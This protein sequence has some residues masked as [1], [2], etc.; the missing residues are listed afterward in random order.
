MSFETLTGTTSNNFFIGNQPEAQTDTFIY[1]NNRMAH[2]P[3]LKYNHSIFAWEFSNDG[4][5]SL[6]FGSSTGTSS[7]KYLSDI[8]GGSWA[9]GYYHLT[10]TQHTWLTSGTTDGYWKSNKGGTGFTTYATGDILY[11]SATNVLSK[12]PIGTSGQVLTVSGSNVPTWT[13]ISTSTTHNTLSELQGG[14]TNEYYHLTSAQHVWLTGG[15]AAGYW[16]AVKGGTGQI[17]YTVGDILY[18]NST[19]TLKTLKIGTL[20]Q[21]LT[22]SDSNEP[23]WATLEPII[24]HNNLIEMQGGTDNEYYHLTSAQHTWLT[25]GVTAGYWSAAKGGTGQT[26]Y[27]VGDI[28][29]AN[30]T[31]TLKTLTVGTIGQVLTVSESNVPSWT[32]I[33][34]ISTHNGLSS[35]QGGTTNEYYHLTSAQHTWLTAGVADGYWGATKGGTGF[36]SY[37]VG[38]ILYASSTS[39][40]KKLTIGNNGQILT[41]AAGVPT[42]AA[43]LTG[44]TG[45]AETALGISAVL[46]DY[47]GTAIGAYS[48]ADRQ[49]VAVGRSASVGTGEYCVTIG[50]YSGGTTSGAY[51]TFVGERAGYNQIS[52]QGPI[53][54]IANTHIGSRASHTAAT[55]GGNCCISIGSGA[56]TNGDNCIVIAS[57]NDTANNTMIVGKGSNTI[58]IGNTAQ[59]DGYFVTNK[60]HIGSGTAGNKSIYAENADTNKPFL[61]FNDTTKIWEICNDGLTAYAM[62]GYAASTAY[63]VPKA[64]S[65]G[66]IHIG[67]I[68]TG[69]TNDSVFIGNDQRL[70]PTTPTNATNGQSLVSNGS[71]VILKGATG[72]WWNCGITPTATPVSTSIVAV[73]GLTIKPG[74]PV[75]FL[76]VDGIPLAQ[77]STAYPKITSVTLSGLTGIYTDYRQCVH[78]KAVAVSNPTFRF[79][80]YS[81]ELCTNKIGHTAN[82]DANQTTLTGVVISAD[83]GSGISGTCDIM[84]NAEAKTN[85]AI[86]ICSFVRTGICTAYNG[87]NLTFAG[88]SVGARTNT[89][90][91]VWLGAPELVTIIPITIPG[92]YSGA[93][94][95]QAFKDRLGDLR[96]WDG[97]N[98]T[99]CQMIAS[100]GVVDT[101]ATQPKI[102]PKLGGYLV[103]ND[104]S[105]LSLSTSTDTRTS[106]VVEMDFSLMFAKPGDRLE[107]KVQVGTNSNARD[108]SGV[109]KFVLD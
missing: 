96:Y 107:L 98:A 55:V 25:G 65:N 60:F 32:T 46:S 23:T 43:G 7:H 58:L 105:A 20:G 30:S 68:P 101:G 62:G 47:E 75:R 85:G 50:A 103:A 93:A 26:A 15:V 104:A 57:A 24:M 21:F 76:H 69:I 95:E 45:P 3:F 87:T 4:V 38:D 78:F 92:T 94:T 54:G 27:T 102:A 106:T 10:A 9:D 31:S 39:A 14:T 71:S 97:P 86:T 18:A 33:T 29:Y 56:T 41:I 64:L 61:N 70:I 80:L 52:G 51:N 66:K 8:Q 53:T 28:L 84:G 99:L 67:W 22:V 74:E 48:N 108:L 17:A 109:L 35:I 83:N 11:S 1:A 88:Q 34:Q 44:L 6:A 13:T 37:T 2:K 42:W 40:L 5:N 79:D 82:F 73:T 100:H 90:L 91:E 89:L 72:R 36:S 81:D 19:T 49:S 77:P 12:L 59:T 63:G 16:S